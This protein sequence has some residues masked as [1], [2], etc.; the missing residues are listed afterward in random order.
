[1]MVVGN[2][3]PEQA[4]QVAIVEDDDVVEELA[5]HASDPA[6]GNAVLPWALWSRAGRAGARGAASLPSAWRAKA[7]SWCV[8]PTCWGRS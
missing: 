7:R 5:A 3:V 8:R 1:V 4:T 6:L 2:V